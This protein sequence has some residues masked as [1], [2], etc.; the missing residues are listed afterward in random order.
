MFIIVII[1]AAYAAV[2]IWW[3]RRD[4]TGSVA[5]KKEHFSDEDTSPPPPPLAEKKKKPLSKYDSRICTI[6]SFERVFG[7]KPT[8]AELESV[9]QLKCSKDIDDSVEKLRDSSCGGDKACRIGGEVPKK[10]ETKRVDKEDTKRVDKEEE[11][12]GS[13]PKHFIKPE[14][15]KPKHCKP[16][17]D[18]EESQ[19]ES[20]SDSSSDSS[21]DSD[22][23]SSSDS[24]SDSGSGSKC[25][26]PATPPAGNCK[27]KKKKKKKRSPTCSDDSND[28]S[29]S[30]FSFYCSTPSPYYHSSSHKDDDPLDLHTDDTTSRLLR[31][32]NSN[33]APIPKC[34]PNNKGGVVSRESEVCIDKRAVIT[35]L[36]SIKKGVDEVSD[37]INNSV[38]K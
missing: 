35:R 4:K 13:E 9:S 10:D 36:Q 19:S 16:D 21:S 32:L 8:S 26:K 6:K 12:C 29:T 30:G 33:T 22:S 20:E 27:E 3:R 11:T 37:L 23:D 24:D 25:K 17:S 2:A 34:A 14:L 38:K 5:P 7:R 18:D 15:K 31:G 1:L 28:W